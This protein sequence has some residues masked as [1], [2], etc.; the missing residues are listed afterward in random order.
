M[1]AKSGKSFSEGMQLAFMFSTVLMPANA[2]TTVH[3][4]EPCPRF[5]LISD[6]SGEDNGK[7]LSA[8]AVGQSWTTATLE[9]TTNTVEFVSR[10]VI[11]L[12]TGREIGS[13]L[14][15]GQLSV[16]RIVG[17]NLFILQAPGSQAAVSAST[18]LAQAEGVKAVYP[19]M[20]R[21]FRVHSSLSPLPNDPLFSQEW[22]LEN[23]DTNTQPAGPDLNVRAAWPISRGDNV[24]VAVA[25]DGFQLDHPEL[26]KRAVAAPHYNFYRGT[27]NGGPASSDANHATCVA[28]LIAAEMDNGIGVTGVAPHACWSER[29]VAMSSI[30]MATARRMPLTRLRRTY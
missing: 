3:F 23:R 28:G 10:V 27:T 1:Q 7:L 15:G 22:H 25:D 21:P 12:E 16:V 4:L 18:N 19:V 30:R 8:A 14:H 2:Q 11:Q 6:S 29:P 17:K 5:Y 26:T 13:Y 9:G 24:L 20:R